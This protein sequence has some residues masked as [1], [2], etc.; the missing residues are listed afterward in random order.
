M[1]EPPR[2]VD[3][4]GLNETSSGGRAASSKK[5]IRWPYKM[6]IMI[7]SKYRNE[8]SFMIMKPFLFHSCGIQ[9]IC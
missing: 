7:D 2:E 8:S 9:T 1:E 4:R 3:E 5:A 6:L